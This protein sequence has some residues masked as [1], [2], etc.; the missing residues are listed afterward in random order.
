MRLT[1]RE[2]HE[3]F[4]GR[5][6]KASDELSRLGKL[7]SN[8]RAN[9]QTEIGREILSEDIDRLDQLWLKLYDGASDRE[10][11]E[12]HYLSDRINR[13]SKKMSLLND[14]IKKIKEAV[15]KQ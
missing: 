5:G 7:D 3:F 9:L 1:E 6:K 4:E 10:V 12:F 14:G 15:N 8:V 2:I 11:A 13:I